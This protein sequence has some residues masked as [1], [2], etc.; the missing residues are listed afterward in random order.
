MN[1]RRIR[2]KLQKSLEEKG[3]V[4]TAAM[5]FQKALRPPAKNLYP[6]KQYIAV[7]PFDEQFGVETSGLIFA[8]DLRSGTKR[9]LYNTGYFGIAPSAFRQILDRLQLNFEEFTFIDL[10]SGKGRALLIA[11]GYPFRS[12]I[13]VELSTKLHE[14][15]LS[16]LAT[17]RGEKRCLDVRSIQG[18]ATEFNFPAGPLVVYLWNSFDGP[19]FTAVL[20]NLEATLAREPREIFILYIEPTLDSVLEASTSWRK[21]WR[22]EFKMSDE[23]YAASAFPPR[24]EICSAYRSVLPG[25]RET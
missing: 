9:D 20:A 14:I 11:S 21:L 25:S 13:G 1:L 2:L 19:V 12:I 5:L 24:A 4:G 6:P 10:G 17:F 15:S 18:D 8:E 16:N 22:A 7:H 3:A 23:D